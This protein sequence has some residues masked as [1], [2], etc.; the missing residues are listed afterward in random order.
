M[1]LGA[2]IVHGTDTTCIVYSDDV[3]I[4]VNVSRLGHG[5]VIRDVTAE[6]GYTDRGFMTI[7][8]VRFAIEGVTFTP[9]QYFVQ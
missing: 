1:S 7:L 9:W 3:D 2:F 5:A 8:I 4:V 6:W